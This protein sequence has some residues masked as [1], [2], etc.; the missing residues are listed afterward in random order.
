MPVADELSVF[1]WQQDAGH[2]AI[3]LGDDPDPCAV[4]EAVGGEHAS[5][6]AHGPQVRELVLGAEIARVEIHVP[7]DEGD[8]ILAGR[9]ECAQSPRCCDQAAEQ[10]VAVTQKLC[11]RSRESGRRRSCAVWLTNQSCWGSS[12]SGPA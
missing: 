8:G 1:L 3:G 11:R 12:A 6:L 4:P 9:L 5:A 10:E 2:G 7:R